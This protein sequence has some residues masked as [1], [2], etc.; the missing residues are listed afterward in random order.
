MIKKIIVLMMLLVGSLLAEKHAEYTYKENKDKE[1]NYLIK[2]KT[3]VEAGSGFSKFMISLKELGWNLHRSGTVISNITASLEDTPIIQ[4]SLSPYFDSKVLLVKFRFKDIKH[5]KE[6]EYAVTDSHGKSIK[7]NFEIIRQGKSDTSNSFLKQKSNKLITLNSK[8]W[9]ASTVDEAIQAVYGISKM[10]KMN[11]KDI[12]RETKDPGFS[13]V[14]DGKCYIERSSPVRVDIE[15]KIN[16]SSIAIFSTMT[17]KPLIAFIQMPNSESRINNISL[18]IS[19]K[20]DGELF[21]VVK[22]ENGKLYRSDSYLVQTSA[23]IEPGT[24]H[25]YFKMHF[26][27]EE[28]KGKDDY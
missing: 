10:M 21:F 7:N 15:S 24:N 5:T 9:E 8:A 22:N 12:S 11:S 27:L 28:I 1:G 19:F 18:P 2:S 6:I 20:K 13:C 25:D 17:S 14:Y 16:L 4:F 23:R 3:K 26:Y